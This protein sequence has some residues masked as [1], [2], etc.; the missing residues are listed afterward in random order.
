MSR[1]DYCNALLAGLP[2]STTAPLQ[3]AQNAAARLIVGLRSCDHVT[4]A[5]QQLHWLP[6]QYRIIY[7]LCALMH[8]VH[9]GRGPSYL[10]KL[11]TA[12]ADLPSRQ[13]L[14]SASSSRYEVP[15]TVLKFDERA[16]SSAAPSAWNSLPS[17]L[18]ELSN[19]DA[20]K[21]QLKFHLFSRAYT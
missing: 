16:F 9:T 18:Q 4:P 12:C 5:L 10:A 7:K 19:I 14:R 8:Q 20:F 15:R 13:R 3:R 21:K 11:V 1:L 6:V 2:K 17:E